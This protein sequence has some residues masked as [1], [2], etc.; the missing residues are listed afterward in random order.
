M[1]DQNKRDE[2]LGV[3]KLSVSPGS[4]TRV[5]G[6]IGPRD[7]PKVGFLEK[8][9][10]QDVTGWTL[11]CSLTVT[12]VVAAFGLRFALTACV[13]PGLPTYITFYPALMVVAVMA[14]FWAG[15]AATSLVAAGTIFW[16]LPPT[17]EFAVGLPADRMGLA[18]F[19]CMGVFI[20]VFAEFH[21]RS[22][23]TLASYE[24][25]AAMREARDALRRHAELVDPARA[26]VIA[27]EMLAAVRDRGASDARPTALLGEA[28]RHSA[29]AAGMAVAALG[30]SVLAGWVFDI[31]SLKRLF[32][33]LATMKANTAVCL[34]ACGGALVFR[35]CR[36]V[37]TALA[38]LVCA[39]T[40]L[41]LAE[42]ITG[43]SLGVDLL[44]FPDY[45][46]MHTVFP[47][48]MVEAT[49]VGLLMA[50]G[51]LLLLDMRARAALWAQQALAVGAAVAGA[52]AGLGYVYDTE[53]LYRFIGYSSMAPH[54][55]V[56]LTLLGLGLLFA[57]TRGLGTMLTTPSPGAQLLRRLLPAMLLAPAVLGWLVAYGAHQGYYSEDMDLVLLVLTM[58][59]SLTAL[60][61]WSARVLNRSDLVRRDTETQLH[62][63]AELMDHAHEPLIVR[64]PGGVILSWN[65][66][67][68]AAYGWSAAD[69]VGRRID[70]LL[71]TGG[72]SQEEMDRQLLSA[73]R[74][75]GELVQITREGRL[76]TVESRQTASRAEDGRVYILESNRDISERRRAERELRQS[77]SFKQAILNSLS[78]NIAVLNREGEIVSVNG[79][80]TQFAM[81]NSPGETSGLAVG[82]NYLDVCGDAVTAGDPLARQALEGIQ[83]VLEG[84]CGQ[85]E[86]EYPCHAPA[87]QRW[88]VMTVTPTADTG[89]AV[90]SHV[91]ITGRKNAEEA[92]LRA[93][94]EWER[95]FDS[96]P[97][98]IAILDE[99]HRVVRA[100]RAM[101]EHLG[102]TP[103][104]C[105]G[106]PCY[107]VVHGTDGPPAF[108]PHA[109]SL[110]DYCEH[111]AEVS[112]ASLGGDF[113]VSTTPI[114]NPEGVLIGSVHVARDI[115][116]RRAAERERETVIEF[117]RLVNETHGT[118]DLV[119]ASTLFFHER[120]G[121][122]AVGIRLKKGDDYP[123]CEARGF[124]A[125]FVEQENSLCVRDASGQLLWD[126]AGR[127]VLECMCGNV[128]RE[129]LDPSETFSTGRGNFWSNRTGEVLSCRME[130]DR[131]TLIRNRCGTEGYESVAL[132]ALRAG[133]EC[134]G[135]L[136][137]NDR[138]KDCFTPQMIALWERMAD[139]LA[140]ALAKNLVE[141]ALRQSEQR[142]AALAAATFEGIAV[143]EDGRFVDANEQLLEI[144]GYTR[145][146]LIGQEVGVGIPPGEREDIQSAIREG[147]ESQVEHQFV[148]RDG[149]TIA[150]EAHGRTIEHQGRKVRFTAVRD[151]TERKQLESLQAFLAQVSGGGT[152]ESFFN[153]LARYLVGCLGM[154]FVC[155][156]R[157][158]G[159]G[160]NATTLA[161]WSDD[162]FE[163]NVTYALVDTPCGNV[164]GNDVCCFPA[165]V[166]QFFPKDEV[167]RE[168]RAESYVGAT[169][170][171]HTGRPI[172][173]IAVIGR[174]PMTNRATAEAVLKR[175]AV[176]AA[177]ELERM[178]AEEA[179]RKSE[180]RYRAL[181][182]TLIEG[183]CIIEMIFDSS[184]NPLDYRFL[185][186][187]W[188]FEAQTGLVGA[189][190]KR[191][192]ELTADLE[193]HWF[194]IFGEIAT[195]GK[196]MRFVN[197]ARPLGRWFEVHAYR[198]GAPEDRRVAILFNDITENKR[199]HDDL[200]RLVRERTLD[201]S[202]ANASLSD[203]LEQ[204]RKTLEALRESTARLAEAQRMARLGNWNWD[205]AARQV[206][207][208]DETFRLLGFEQQKTTPSYRR[209]L[210]RVYPDDRQQVDA[211]LKQAVSSGIP[212]RNTFR[213]TLPNGEIRHLSGQAEVVL[214]QNG[215]SR[216]FAGTLMDTTEQVRAREEAK[217]RN[218]QL[219]QAD[220]MV[221]L[222][223]LTS[224]V[225]HEINNPN[226]AIMSNTTL[227][228]DAWTSIHP[229]LERFYEDFGDFVVGGL[230]YSRGRE[231]FPRMLKDVLSASRRIEAIVTELRDFARYSPEDTLSPVEIGPVIESARVLL[232]NMIKK[233]TDYFSV[234]VGEEL[235]CVL[236]NRQ[237]IEQ[238][239][240]NLI[241][242]ACQA[243]PSR[244]RRLAVTASFDAEEE[245]VVIAVED[246]GSGISEEN[247]R[248]L[249][250]PFFTTKRHF[251]GTGLGL[252]VSFNIV[253]EHRGLLQ[254]FSTPGEG[255]RAVLTLRT[256]LSK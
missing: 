14:G 125:A 26:E 17:G 133:D 132:I 18:L 81:C 134:L 34:L 229:I 210:E 178:G 151:I 236:A 157:L 24:R 4:G 98:L 147:R 5:G 112:E 185:E 193:D 60:I 190:G 187:N 45:A 91:N 228:A 106:V 115:T 218:Q 52:V 62:N 181:F 224:G 2:R 103:G 118:A 101:A 156:D 179:L 186:T 54:T 96:V 197:E 49:A 56:S 207:W 206:H 239:L 99:Q 8:F 175:V 107:R 219:L 28:L 220:K 109:R 55:A 75:E 71:C 162:H 21:R 154:N 80:W 13:G 188:S 216:K 225:A 35:R 119:R 170:W 65:H 146:E 195:T 160:L 46:D 78:A 16:I 231:E 120:S 250:D 84:R 104:Q 41:T 36:A 3:G 70:A 242:N 204:H 138:R 192:R 25:E 230:D 113:L 42:Y 1:K 211:G 48:R 9:R 226:H 248:H 144:F 39:V 251:G 38:G 249:G 194:R 222:G 217:I 68:E 169:L 241:Q 57:R 183:F 124:P 171:G 143:I 182:D 102:L 168:L 153:A 165:S 129:R 7:V 202:R 176:R 82:T 33:G 116:E 72:F 53:Q 93:K 95:T 127:T 122:E 238:V 164:V 117:L 121:C 63:L 64:E 150:V 184:G 27:G 198:M 196:P 43:A 40:G 173:L 126:S 105:V 111:T 141:D 213:V 135:L 201:L 94:E 148:R 59:L 189:R 244:D 254:F 110:A 155:I 61:F 69:A 149:M 209:F 44:L 23:D 245:A 114:L 203:S 86:M 37:R 158:E 123:Y 200:E 128:I 100:N 199:S 161:V 136:Q 255:T 252:W 140:V 240:I 223:I 205:I 232:S 227:I 142:F 73:G 32:P 215:K 50:G 67:A 92:I 12:M 88:F 172:G 89:G 233:S 31:D 166:C 85:F 11:R 137:L 221:S 15:V 77:E 208:S 256:S 47:G 19:T 139:Y 212:Y 234:S 246:E 152:G 131:E 180:E 214:D 159:D 108:C 66:G 191:I 145:E 20:S 167:L 235:P 87:E 10:A 253:R 30:L 177:A 83:S 174:S 79:P 247:L 51:S 76:V 74:W 29:T 22:R 6:D 130:A 58:I 243:L 97:D 163:D 237:R 90:I